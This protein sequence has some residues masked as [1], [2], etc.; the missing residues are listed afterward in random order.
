[1][2]CIDIPYLLTQSLECGCYSRKCSYNVFHGPE[3]RPVWMGQN[4]PTTA[5]PS[6]SR[7]PFPFQLLTGHR[8]SYA[9]P[10]TIPQKG[11]QHP[12]HQNGHNFITTIQPLSTSN[13]SPHYLRGWSNST[14]SQPHLLHAFI[15]FPLAQ[16]STRF[17][18]CSLPH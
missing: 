8:K 13:S 3:A 14:S 10:Q 16:L 6:P 11:T 4:T 12:Q 5:P 9:S 1:M 2:T 17:H 15:A 18:W 7:T